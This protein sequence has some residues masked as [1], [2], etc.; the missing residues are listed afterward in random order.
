LL[1]ETI[2]QGKLANVTLW[3]SKS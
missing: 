1:R 3:Q 2:T